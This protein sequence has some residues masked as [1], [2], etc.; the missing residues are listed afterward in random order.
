MRRFFLLT[1]I[2]LTACRQE[3]TANMETPL[4]PVTPILP[5]ATEIQIIAATETPLPPATPAPTRTP[6]TF[7]LPERITSGPINMIALGDSQTKGDGDETGRGYTVRILD[8]VNG[9]FPESTMTSLAQPGWNSDALI[10]GDQG[11]LGQ[12]PRA[13]TEVGTSV[14]QGRPA[15]VFVW[16]GVNDIWNLYTSG[17]VS[18]ELEEQN[19]RRFE[20]NMDEILLG[21]RSAGAHTLVGLLDDLSKRPAASSLTDDARIRIS[22]QVNR[23]NT[24]ITQKAGQYGVL[25]VDFFTTDIF[26]NPATVSAD[27]FHPNA[28]GYDLIAQKWYETL[29]AILP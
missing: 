7:P 4:P 11:V 14:S 3:I 27:G 9:V 8:G 28:A 24:I 12:L 6:V 16:I 26:T 2:F 1:L 13:I 20:E 17:T 5:A 29:S 23:Y 25:T 15:V 18:A 22:A 19:A 21:L 10:N